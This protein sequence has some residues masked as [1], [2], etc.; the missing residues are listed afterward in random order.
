MIKLPNKSKKGFTLVELMIVITVIAILATIAV[1][2]FTRV[3]K[4]ARDT[5][6]KAEVKSLQTALQAYYTE[7][8]AYPISTTAITTE[9]VNTV[10]TGLS[11]DYMSSLP[12]APLGST[13][14]YQ[15]Y[16]YITT[17][18]GFRYAICVDLETAAVGQEL[19]VVNTQNSAGEGIADAAGACVP[20]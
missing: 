11:P 5:K 6:R 3:Q 14:N 18:D 8:Q 7:H 4:Q 19:W 13:G 20:K 10:L 16:T 1:V 17:D 2:S 9:D 12:I 15:K